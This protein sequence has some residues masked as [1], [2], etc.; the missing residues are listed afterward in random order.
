MF[1]IKEINAGNKNELYRQINNYLTALISDDRDWLAGLA[2]ASALLYQTL[3]DINWAGFYL[4][5]GNELVLG[6]FQGKPAC[7]RIGPGR[8]VCGTAAETRKVQIVD[9]VEKFPGH[10]AC[11]IASRSEIVV[12]I[13][14]NQRLI[15]VLD[16]DSPVKARFDDEDAVGLS[17]FVSILNRYL[18]W[19]ENFI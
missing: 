7:I 3:P 6:P 19:P 2:N 16:I 5:K 10:I 12:P 17:E 8:G 1:E 18:N 13:I 9:D 15:G 11:D 4:W 14:K